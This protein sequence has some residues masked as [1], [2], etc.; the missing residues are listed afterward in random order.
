MIRPRLPKL[1]NSSR[2]IRS[3]LRLAWVLVAS[4]ALFIA[5]HIDLFGADTSTS[6]DTRTGGRIE[7]STTSDT[8]APSSKLKPPA[9]RKSWGNPSTL[10]DHFNRHGK[11]FDAKD[12]DDYAAQAWLFLQRAKSEGLPAKRDESGVL[13]VYDPKSKSFAS[14]NRNGTTKT[15]FKP[16]RRDYFDD[17]PGEKVDLRTIP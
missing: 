14:Y 7:K 5:E 15:F 3:V 12:A 11:D 16:R 17:Q 10:Q 2:Q 13:R 8:N 6:R 9:T 1:A 4:L